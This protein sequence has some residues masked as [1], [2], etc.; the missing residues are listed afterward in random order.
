MVTTSPADAAM[1]LA[2]CPFCGGEANDHRDS[3]GDWEVFCSSDESCTA[4]VAHRFPTREQAI[5]AWNRRPAPAAIERAALERAAKVAE[6]RRQRWHNERRNHVERE[7]P[8]GISSWVRFGTKAVEA[9]EIAAAIRALAA[10]ET[11]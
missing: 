11:K 10:E 6:A 8:E 5:A 1:P 9:T 7:D 3:D 2:S 4:D